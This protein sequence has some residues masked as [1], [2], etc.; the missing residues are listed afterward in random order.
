MSTILYRGGSVYTTAAR[1]AD[2]LIVRDGRIIWLGDYPS[3]KSYAVDQVVDFDGALIAPGFVDSHVHLSATGLLLSGVDLTNATSARHA[4][5]LLARHKTTTQRIVLGHGWDET[6]WSDKEIWT[7]DEV[8]RV[9]SDTPVYL[10][11][12]DVHSAIANHNLL[13]QSGLSAIG[14][15]SAQQH[16]TLREIALSLIN[17]QQTTNAIDVALSRAAALGIVAVH[18]N[19]G[20]VVSGEVD[21]AACLR[22]GKDSRNPV[23][24][25]YWGDLDVNRAK[26]LGAHGAAGDLFID[27]SIGSHT[28]CLSSPY[29]DFD[30]HG[31]THIAPGLVAHHLIVC[32]ELGYQGGFHAIGDGALTSIVSGLHEAEA[33][34]G[35][36]K[37]RAARHRIEHAE[38][39]SSAHIEALAYYGVVASVQPRFDEFWAGPDGMYEQRLG[40]ERV[41]SM[42]PFA[43]LLKTGVVLSFSSDAPVTPL[44]PWEAIKAA[45]N[46]THTQHRISARAA[47]AAHTRGGWR[48]VG[49]DESGVLE[50]GAPAH[51]AVWER[52][53]LTVAVADERVSRWSTDER[54][55][56]A[57]LP[58]LADK[59]PTALATY[60]AGKSIY[61][62][63]GVLE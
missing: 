25:G 9:I 45:I 40:S 19:A 53:E 52:S 57:G 28:A 35:L 1:D 12:I 50:I 55:A 21:F 37:V 14:P 39:L 38:M 26:C 17:E 30:S 48:A 60:R 27:G 62:A 44:G 13:Q 8:S 34:V 20:P 49:D 15:V 36:A 5:D 11:R 16:H 4:L 61:S 24:Y 47:F 29:S 18:E 33:K 63:P 10:S 3:A 43:Q 42:N 54:S 32:S 6:N 22:A 46:H 56:T 51:F 7:V 31:S 2:C 58:N 41:S 23:V 59:I